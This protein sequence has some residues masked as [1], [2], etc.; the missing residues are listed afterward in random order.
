MKILL[1]TN[2]VMD[3]LLEREPF[4]EASRE[5]FLLVEEKK[6]QGFLSASSITTIHY[7]L[8]KAISKDEADETINILL[9]L[10]DITPLDK[11]TLLNALKTNGNDFEDSVIYN[12]A[13]KSNID[14]LITRDK[15]GFKNSKVSILT[16][17]EFIGF[18]QSLMLKDN[19]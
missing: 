2:V 17:V 3:L 11:D 15:K 14:Y 16:P 4:F 7:L 8:N 10:F 5:I 19:L 13:E 12:S 18:F 9:K 6:V 1:D